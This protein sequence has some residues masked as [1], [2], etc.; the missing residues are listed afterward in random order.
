[1]NFLPIPVV[2]GGVFALLIVEKI[3]GSPLS[4][5]LQEVMTYA[6]LALIAS[7]FLYVTYNDIIRLIL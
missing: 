1:M 3:K 5:R 6:G 7:L 4:I 2:D